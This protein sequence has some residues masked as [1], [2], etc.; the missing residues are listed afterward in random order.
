MKMEMERINS[1]HLKDHR[2]PN[3]CGLLG[4]TYIPKYNLLIILSVDTPH[5]EMKCS[6]DLYR[7]RRSEQSYQHRSC[8]KTHNRLW[9]F[10]LQFHLLYDSN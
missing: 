6:C 7:G 2:E 1:S 5:K 4:D 3:T 10:Y 9:A 8:S